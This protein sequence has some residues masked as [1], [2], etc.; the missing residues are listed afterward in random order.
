M[1]IGVV[2]QDLNGV[3]YHRLLKPFSLLKDDYD[4]IHCEGINSEVF[5]YGLDVVIFSRILP[6]VE[7]GKFI[8]EF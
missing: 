6:V 1:K 7:Q 4:L 8:R 5:D 2:F 3:T